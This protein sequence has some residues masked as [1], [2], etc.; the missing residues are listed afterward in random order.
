MVSLKICVRSFTEVLAHLGSTKPFCTAGFLLQWCFLLSFAPFGI[1][2]WG[3]KLGELSLCAPNAC[4]PPLPLLAEH[5]PVRE[6]ISVHL[7]WDALLQ[8]SCPCQQAERLQLCTPREYRGCPIRCGR[9]PVHG[10]A[11]PWDAPG[12]GR[13]P[14]CGVCPMDPGA[15]A[16]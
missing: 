7:P 1:Y 16:S 9:G 15:R 8:N 2:W 14:R 11:A 10:R 3:G 12:R 5:S 13:E 6:D 4:V